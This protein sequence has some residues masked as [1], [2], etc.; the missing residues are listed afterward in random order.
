ML[1]FLFAECTVLCGMSQNHV[2]SGFVMLKDGI[3]LWLMKF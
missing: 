3:L 1:L 2:L